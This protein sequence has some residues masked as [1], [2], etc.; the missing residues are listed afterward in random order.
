MKTFLISVNASSASGPSSR[1]RPDCLK[2]PN[3]VQYRTEEC[4]L[5]DRLPASTAR[6]RP[7]S[8]GRRRGSRSSR[9]GRRRVVGDPDRLGLVLERQHRHHRPEDLLGVARARRA[10]RGEHGRREPEAGPVRRAAA[11]RHRRV[12]GD[13]GGNMSRAGRPRS[14]GPSRC[15]VSAGSPTLT[16][17]TAGSSSSMNRSSTDRWTRIRDRAQQSWPA[18]SNTAYGAVAAACSRSASAKTMLA[19]L[20]PSSS[21]SRLTCLAQPAMICWPTSVE[22]VKHDLAHGRDGRRTAGRPPS[23]CRAAPGARPSGSPASQRQLAE[24]DRGQ[25][26][27]LGRLGDHGVAGGQGR[28]QP[29]GQDRHREV[30]RH[31]EPDD[32][33]R[34]V[35]RDVQA[36]GHRDLPAEQPLRAPPSSTGSTSRTLPASQRALPMGWPE[37]ATSSWASSSPCAS[38]CVG[39]RAQQPGP[40][41]GRDRPPGRAARRGARDRRV[42][43]LAPSVPGTV[44]TGC[45]VAGFRIV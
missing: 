27:Q 41:A 8:P 2:P 6:A 25:R 40:V 10:D 34:L 22:P 35:E 23:P 3:G 38:T 37:F 18:L 43:L 7:G 29:P 31:D 36:A 26:R 32:A 11:E 44:V 16:P 42:G 4:E 39:E 9:T 28:R 17:C 19:L 20:P 45:S 30:P 12:V 24:P 13:I 5:T 21:V 1:P 15:R 14:A 33:E